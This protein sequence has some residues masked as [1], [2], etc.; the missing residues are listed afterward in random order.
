VSRPPRILHTPLLFWAGGFTLFPWLV[1]V[2]PR[3]RGDRALLEHEFVHCRQ[4]R[5]HGWFAFAWRY[6]L[7]PSFRQRMEVEAYRTS[8][9]C[10]ASAEGCARALARGY[11]LGLSE[12][13]ALA[14]LS[15]E[16][17]S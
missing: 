8:I 13:Q 12:A 11:A 10:G 7:L 2:H 3:C 1:L 14:L 6:L 15:C 17:R 4:M 9:A 16:R 5:E